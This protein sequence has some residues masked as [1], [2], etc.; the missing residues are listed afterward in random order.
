MVYVPTFTIKI[1]HR[2][3][4][5]PFVPWLIWMP[6]NHIKL[7]SSQIPR[8]TFRGSKNIFIAGVV[9]NITGCCPSQETQRIF[10]K[11]FKSMFTFSWLHPRKLT[12]N[13]TI[14]GLEMILLF[15]GGIFRFHVSFWGC[16]LYLAI[17]LPFLLIHIFNDP[18]M[19]GGFWCC[20]AI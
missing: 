10:L 11:H 15:Q 1:R 18:V 20:R 17:I 3:V 12:W 2:W 16:I 13:P 5:I 19:G 6:K 8:Y 7:P 9:S 14:G 4:N